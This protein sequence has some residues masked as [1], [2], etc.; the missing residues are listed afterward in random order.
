MNKEVASFNLRE[1]SFEA[2]RLICDRV[3]A[4]G[5]IFSVDINNEQLQAS[6]AGARQKYVLSLK[7]EKKKKAQQAGVKRKAVSE[8][9]DHLKKPVSRMILMPC[10]NLLM[11][12]QR[13]LRNC[14]T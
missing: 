9:T 5:G 11:S 7:D 14:V 2:R 13:R 6:C 1:N 8:E 10:L 4:I 12:L 3:H